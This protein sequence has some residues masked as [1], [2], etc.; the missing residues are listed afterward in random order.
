[1]MRG[2]IVRSPK[3]V[4]EFLPEAPWVEA[5]TGNVGL[6][7]HALVQWRVAYDVV[8]IPVAAIILLL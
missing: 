1:M 6:N 8:A 7:L 4:C 5:I 3:F 2:G